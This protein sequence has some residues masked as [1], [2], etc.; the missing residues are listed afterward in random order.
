LTSVTAISQKLNY[1]K[2]EVH[3]SYKFAESSFYGYKEH[4]VMTDGLMIIAFVVISGE[5]VM[6]LF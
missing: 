1:S 6:V 2:D 5:K 4:L 3:L